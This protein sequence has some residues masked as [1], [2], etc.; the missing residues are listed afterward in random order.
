MNLALHYGA[1]R[2][3]IVNVGDLKPM[4]FPTEFFLSMAW[5][6]GRWPKESIG[7][8][9]ELWASREFGA[10]YAPE[11]AAIVSTYA[12]YNARRKPELLE[13]STYSQVN[14]READT[15]I[16]DFRAITT[17]AEE[18]YKKLP[19]EAKDAFYELVLYPTKAS[20]VV[21]ELYVTAGKNLLY[22]S[23]G[24]ASTNQLAREARALFQTDAELSAY[25]NLKLAGGKWDHMMDQTHIGYTFWNEPPVNNMPKVTEIELP[26]EAKMGVAVEGSELAWPDAPGE[27]NLPT[28]DV[29]NQQSF[30]GDIF[31]RGKTPF[32]FR[33]SAAAPWIKIS[34]SQGRVEQEKRVW[35]SVDWRHA[36]GGESRG[37]VEISSSNGEKV[38]VKV[39]AFH[40]SAPEPEK[41]DGFVEADGYV[42][43]EAVAGSARTSPG[44]QDVSFSCGAR[45]GGSH[46][47]SHAQ[48]CAGSRPALRHFLGR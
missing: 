22:A 42:S 38:V 41:L 27:A 21:N 12:K 19:E 2:I 35:I 6:P 43:V 29:F 36:P 25:Y 28:F 8:F 4:E 47:R 34:D 31:N 15:V 33:A 32:T 37:S 16:A 13:P 10:Q 7:E 14:Y 18:I 1:D 40:P 46:S 24:R 9:A 45:S 48:F 3:W 44:I 30:Y 20:A 23:Q 39:A 11:I 26:S 17:T 5:N